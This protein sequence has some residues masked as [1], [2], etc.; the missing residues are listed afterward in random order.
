MT[1]RERD[2][3]EQEVGLFVRTCRQRIEVLKNAVSGEAPT[4]QTLAW[5]GGEGRAGNTNL[6]AHWHGVVSDLFP[7]MVALC[8]FS[9]TFLILSGTPGCCKTLVL[10]FE[11]C[12]NH[13]NRNNML[14]RSYQAP[15][16]VMSN[17]DMQ[18]SREWSGNSTRFCTRFCCSSRPVH[19]LISMDI[20][21][22]PSCHSFRNSRFSCRLTP[23][24]ARSTVRWRD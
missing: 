9:N 4:Q 10:N 6:V 22:L 1:E 13:D 14:Y 2:D 5:I 11:P 24:H 12:R 7:G 16:Q 23:S 18:A 17:V 8:W 21:N 15:N 19:S 20:S 3:L